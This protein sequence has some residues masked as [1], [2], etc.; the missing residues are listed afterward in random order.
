MKNRNLYNR[1]NYSRKLFLM[2]MT[3][4][5]G[6]S[7]NIKT[8]DLAKL[9]IKR[10]LICRPNKRLGNLLLITPLV[11]EV[12][13]FFPNSRIDLFVRG[14]LAN[15][16]FEQY[17]NVSRIITLPKKP[18]KELIKYIKVFISLKRENYDLVINVDS[19]S[20][21][22]RLATRITKGRIHFFNETNEELKASIKDYMHSAKL[23][24]YNFRKF[25]RQKMAIE[26]KKEIPLLDIK[27]SEAELANGKT[28]LNN[29][30]PPTKKTIGIYTFATG[31]KCYTKEWW[32]ELYAKLIAEFEPKYN[33]VEILP[34]ENE[35]QI[36]FA[37][38]SYYSKDIR[39][40]ASVMAHMEVYLGADC[41]IMHLASA[42]KV[43]TIGLFS[44]TSLDVYHPYGNNSIAIK[45]NER[46][47][48]EVFQLFKMAFNSQHPISILKTGK[49]SRPILDENKS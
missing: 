40:I 9:E 8:K 41:G 33:I 31:S 17:N 22:G 11:Q 16:V 32:S 47:V 7:T 4:Y 10:I 49:K 20:S 46:S 2:S 23:P 28:I 3:R 37:A 19:Y 39:E 24:I 44:T 30:V 12:V 27:L 14:G 1:I 35:S 45:T 26:H 43:Q 18:F 29:I 6:R 13:E 21:S 15:V 36:D 25:L 42:A 5:I 48:E 34:I 38:T